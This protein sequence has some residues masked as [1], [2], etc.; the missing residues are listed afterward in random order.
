[1]KKF[2]G[3]GSSTPPPPSPPSKPP[4]PPAKAATP[5]APAK[6]P[7]PTESAKPVTSSAPTIVGKWRE[8]GSSDTTEFHAD[9]S[10]TEKTGSGETIRGRYSV[11]D[12]HLKINLDGVSDQLSFPVAIA[13]D[14][15]EMTDP[16]GKITHYERIS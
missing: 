7:A 4:T 8:P 15:L 13:A 1:M 2:F 14:K 11:R 9:G 12:K 6:S 3:F 16:D 10:V 5:P